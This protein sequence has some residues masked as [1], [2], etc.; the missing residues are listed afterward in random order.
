MSNRTLKQTVLGGHLGLSLA[1]SKTYTTFAGTVG[2][3]NG[4]TGLVGTGTTF[5]SGMAGK[6]FAIKLNADPVNPAI[7][8]VTIATFVD[9]T[10]VTLSDA[11]AG[12][13]LTGLTG[14]SEA[15]NLSSA[16]NKPVSGVPANWPSLGTLL[17]LDYKRNATFDM[18]KAPSPA[19]LAVTGQLLKEMAPTI[20]MTL[21]E[22]SEDLLGSVFGVALPADGTPFTP[23]SNPGLIV[24]W[25]QLSYYD[26]AANKGV[27][28][29]QF[30]AGSVEDWKTQDGQI[31]PVVKVQIYRNALATGTS[32]LQSLS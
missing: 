28:I 14:F 4:D 24:G 17:A 29:E 3:T 15:V 25:W 9:T 18:V 10:H 30:G 11:W 22:V 1:G 31:K 21:N 12:D 7:V 5:T 27:T 19:A 26:Q 2:V 6:T 23:E 20:E 8:F 16:T 13:T 32:T